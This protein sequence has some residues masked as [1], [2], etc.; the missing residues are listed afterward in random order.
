MPTQKKIEQAAEISSRLKESNGFYIINYRGLTVKQTET[1]R[2]ALRE[3]D[4]TCTVYKNN[5]VRLCL[6]EA[7]LPNMDEL[8]DGPNAI[9]F[10]NGDL[11]AAAKAIK[12]FA[13]EAPVL[14]LKGGY[15]D[16]KAID[17]AAANAIADLPTRDELLATL[18][19]TMQG[20][21]QKFARCCDLIREQKEEQPAA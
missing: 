8:L 13:K 4:A 14:E 11:A 12:T 19:R 10:Y 17:A 5:V 18:L 1:L 6:K 21:M 2:R 15:A 16:G 3:A 20:P 9:V 7:G